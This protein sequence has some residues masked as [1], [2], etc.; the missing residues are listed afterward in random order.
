MHANT[1]VNKKVPQVSTGTVIT[2]KSPMK[3]VFHARKHKG[4]QKSSSGV[5]RNG[6]HDQISHEMRFPCTQTQGSTT[7]T[8]RSVMHTPKFSIGMRAP[9]Q[10]CGLATKNDGRAS[11]TK[12]R[13]RRAVRCEY[14]RAAKAGVR[15]L[16]SLQSAFP[17]V[18]GKATRLASVKNPEK[19]CT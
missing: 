16:N 12:S 3:C 19:P 2:T 13:A 6:N 18:R 15:F 17:I 4:Q 5:N 10:R 1:R 7:D 11:V 9:R 14:S 8:C